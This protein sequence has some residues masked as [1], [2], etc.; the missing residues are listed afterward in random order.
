MS[1]NLQKEQKK[2]LKYKRL[3]SRKSH[4]Q[5]SDKERSDIQSKINK[6]QNDIQEYVNAYKQTNPEKQTPEIQA[7]TN[8]NNILAPKSANPTE[9]KLN[10]SVPTSR[11]LSKTTL[12]Q[13]QKN[14]SN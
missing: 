12:T 4:N 1:N 10:A 14:K 5:L 9:R 13:N 7:T 3:E 8:N 11:T 6:L 2:E